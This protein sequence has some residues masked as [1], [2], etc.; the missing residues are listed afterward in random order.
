[1]SFLKSHVPPI[2][3]VASVMFMLVF[4][5]SHLTTKPRMGVDE[6]MTMEVAHTF[7]EF[8]KFTVST[9]PGVFVERA[10]TVAATGYPVTLPLALTYKIFGFGLAV[11]RVY[12]IVWILILF[13]S[14]WW[15]GNIYFSPFA[16][17]SA[18]ALVATF[19]TFYDLGRTATGEL[20]GFVFFLWG[21]HM[22]AQALEKRSSQFFLFSGALLG[23]ALATK[24]SL[25]IALIP[26]M[27]LVFLWEHKRFSFS[28]AVTF[29]AG[30]AVPMLLWVL[31]VFPQP[32]LLATWK[33]AYGFLRN[34]FGRP[35]L[36]NF[37]GNIPLLVSSSTTLYFFLLAV[38]VL[39]AYRMKWR[40]GATTPSLVRI[41]LLYALF[42]F[43][44]FM[45]SPGWI[46]YLFGTELALLFL[47]PAA[48][49]ILGD[50]FQKGA[51]GWTIGLLVMVQ[52]VQL[53]W[54]SR[55]LSS[56]GP[57]V[58][59]SYINQEL[60]QQ[61]GA[62]G[63][64]NNKQVAAL[65]PTARRYQQFQWTGTPL[66]GTNPLALDTEHLPRLILVAEND[67]PV[68]IDPYENVFTTHYALKRTFFTNQ[69][70]FERVR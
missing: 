8:G 32:W 9:A 27:L 44:Y 48:L 3:G 62:V 34:P 64:M 13:F 19:A 30:A 20:P 29:A 45:R 37:R 42:G 61:G 38:A 59:S 33:D 52:I 5:F 16:A 24:P 65:V 55:I 31:S 69:Y 67:K 70:L 10:Y 21:A 4:S 49:E 36:A 23:L 50:R 58:I 63:V 46:R 12:M 68:F 43:F 57:Q 40:K 25:Y 15:I 14:I 47:L 6:S 1:M 39:A 28:S 26:A 51:G 35:L 53:F 18:V 7:L 56:D 60:A 41:L 2:L 22:W 66:V 11:T 17:A 54:F